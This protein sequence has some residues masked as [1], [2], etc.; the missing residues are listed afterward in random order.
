MAEWGKV[1]GSLHGSLKWRRASKGARALWTTAL[2]WCIDQEAS[3]G[4]IPSDAL[5]ILDGTARDAANLVDVQL[6]DVTPDGWRF[7]DW[8]D[9]QRTREQIIRDRES[10]AQRQRRAREKRE[11]H[12]E[13][14][15]VSHGVT[16]GVSHAARTEQSREEESKEEQIGASRPQR[17]TQL[18]PSWTPNPEHL[19]R[20]Q[21][22]GLDIEREAT[23]FRAH[24]EEKGRTAKSWNAAFTRWLINA[25]EY[26]KRDQARGPRTSDRQGEIL[27][28]EREAAMAY[29]AQQQ[30]LEI[31]Q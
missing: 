24:A 23:K 17:A 22:S 13:Q 4:E 8:H 7:H 6:W 5:R 3:E 26:A 10:A 28:R 27:R 25:A 19:T 30:R 31:E 21:T 2:S 14:S 18:P 9:R 20:A 12:A 11:S 29:D 1:Y 15:R 16:N